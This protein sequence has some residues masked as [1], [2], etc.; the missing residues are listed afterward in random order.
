MT[1]GL[2]LLILKKLICQRLFMKS[3]SLILLLCLIS[4]SVAAE[5]KTPEKL[6]NL[7]TDYHPLPRDLSD[8]FQK[9]DFV[10]M[11]KDIDNYGKAVE[12]CNSVVCCDEV[13]SDIFQQFYPSSQKELLAEIQQ[14]VES[15]DNGNTYVYGY[16]RY[17]CQPAGTIMEQILNGKKRAFY[18]SYLFEILTFL[19]EEVSEFI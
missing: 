19:S 18:K 17:F 4:F 13:A 12:E 6:L 10:Q 7:P 1:N 2:K 11:L 3:F 5:W 16:C 14:A 9:L 15:I 8:E